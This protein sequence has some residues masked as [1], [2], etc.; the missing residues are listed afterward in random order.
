MESLL[1][2]VLIILI[3]LVVVV[4]LGP[5]YLER[6]ARRNIARLRE[7][8]AELQ[9][10]SRE[11]RRYER[12][13]ASYAPARAAVY[14][15]QTDVAGERLAAM[16][17]AMAEADA[18]LDEARCPKM[19]IDKLPVKQFVEAPHLVG[20]ILNDARRLGRARDRLAGA[21]RAGQETGAA[22]EALAALPQQ[23]AAERTAL[24]GRLTAATAAVEGERGQGI[25][26]LDELTGHAEQME[27]LLADYERAAA[28]DASVTALDGG[29]M[30]LESLATGLGQLEDKVRDAIQEREAL[31]QHVQRAT[32]EL[33]NAQARTKAGPGA[34]DAPPPVGLLLRR[35]AAL[36][37]ESAPAHRRRREYA[38]AQADVTR[39]ERLTA[40]SRDLTAT[41]RQARLLAERD[42][43]AG[44]T[45]GIDGLQ[46]ELNGLIERAGREAGRPQEAALAERAAQLRAKASALAQQQDEAIDELE[47]AALAARERLERAWEAGQHLL[48]LADND[49]LAR[50]RARLLDDFVAAQRRPAALEAFR[51]DV[52]AFEDVANPWVTRVQATRQLIGRLRG[53]LP[54]LIDAARAAAAPWNC[55]AGDVVAIQQRAADFETAQ[56]QFAGARYRRDAERLMDEVAAIEKEIEERYAQIE[57]RAG[58]LRY[59]EEDVAE[60]LRLADQGDALPPDHP[61]RAKRERA[62][63]FIAHHLSQARTMAR[64]DDAAQALMRAADVANKMAL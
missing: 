47:Q 64:Y 17:A 26:A 55:L 41:A 14:R 27:A 6:L 42:D 22:L 56:A 37:N 1:S 59:L 52:A 53:R 16:A 63:T 49:P 18:L 4:L 28:P 11:H 29:A 19:F 40:L 20:I 34:A 12:M 5:A 45:G 51:R 15:Q 33:D 43:G 48:P 46:Q 24:A 60:I 39:A 7:Y 38:A 21:T 62:R 13:L 25:E 10:L 3:F 31:D 58:R 36:L 35:A 44:L 9:D 8:D 32:A 50:R 57:E 61:E 30:A 54:D 23:L 2:A